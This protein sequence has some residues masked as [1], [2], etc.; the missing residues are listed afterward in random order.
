[1][2]VFSCPSRRG[3][4]LL[5]TFQ[6]AKSFEFCK[7]LLEVFYGFHLLKNDYL[8]NWKACPKSI[9]EKSN[10]ILVFNG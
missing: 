9:Y 10:F 5:W 1:M 7:V 3:N 2:C 6:S 8:A 4:G